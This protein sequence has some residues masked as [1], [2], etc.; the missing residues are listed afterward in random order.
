MKSRCNFN[1]QFR[2]RGF[3][4]DSVHVLMVMLISNNRKNGDF[5]DGN[6]DG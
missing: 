5:V 4:V 1:A 6:V 3:G 2:V